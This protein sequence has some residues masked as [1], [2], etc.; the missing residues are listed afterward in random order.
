MTSSLGARFARASPGLHFASTPRAGRAVRA[1]MDGEARRR[2]GPQLQRVPAGAVASRPEA[3][4]RSACRRS[5]CGS[6]RPSR[7]GTGGPAPST[8]RIVSLTRCIS[9]RCSAAF[10]RAPVN[11][12]GAVEPKLAVHTRETFLLKARGHAGGVVI[13]PAAPA[14]RA[15]GSAPTAATGPGGTGRCGRASAQ[16]L[17]GEVADR[18]AREEHPRRPTPWR[19]S[20]ERVK[21]ATIGSR[22]P[23][24]KRSRS[25]TAPIRR[26][27]RAVHRHVGRRAVSAASSSGVF[28][29]AAAQLIPPWH[30]HRRPGRWRSRCAGIIVSVRVGGTPA[31]R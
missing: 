18:R 2:V 7:N 11:A 27:A 20:A 13:R 23:C 12:L 10:Q 29:S 8:R 25:C 24:G 22:W 5:R 3:A 9:T 1:T 26:E 6:T 21:S 19:N 28:G 14:G 31:V 15:I 4:P 16:A 30:A 17:R